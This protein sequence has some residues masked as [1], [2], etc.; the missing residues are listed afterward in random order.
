[1]AIRQRPRTTRVLVVSLVCL[2]LAVITLDYRQGQ[3]GPLAGLG[4]AALAV[5]VPMQRAVTDVTRPV[6]D[7]F[8][9]LAHLP[10]LERDNQLLRDQVR[11]LT[12]EVQTDAFDQQQVQKLYGLLQLRQSL[13]P[14][15][16]SAVVTGNGLSNFEW[17]ITIDK[18]SAD[19]IA[20][21][22]PV[23]TGTPSAP[24][25][26]GHV[27]D[28]SDN[29][30]MVQLIIDRGNSVAA[31][32]S[33]SRKAGAI[34]GQGEGDLK[35][36]LVE[37]GTDVAGN[38]TV[39]TQGYCVAGEPGLYPP[40]ILIGQ[41]SRTIPEENSIQE[42]VNVRPAVDFA[43]LEFVLVLQARTSC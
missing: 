18:G 3:S 8:S 14:R 31:V 36:E 25:L 24:L 35:M 5:M 21:N 4:R 1:M 16:V 38:E 26:V 42:S 11:D 28:V 23:V 2:S 40:G 39:F 6:A 7:F 43:T 9:G 32:L 12:G 41:V 17:T 27:V 29:A 33:G 34:E 22:M 19:G 30:S 20:E 37:P 13:D 15:S 10:S